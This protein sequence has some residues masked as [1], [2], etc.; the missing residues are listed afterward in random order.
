MEGGQ[1]VQDDRERLGNAVE[2]HD[3]CCV[4]CPVGAGVDP[5]V[6]IELPEEGNN[7]ERASSVP[8]A[9]RG[10]GGRRG[11]P[12]QGNG[13]GDLQI[14]RDTCIAAAVS[15]ALDITAD[16]NIAVV[17]GKIAAALPGRPQG[18]ALS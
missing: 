13:A 2:A 11:Q 7:H 15:T 10:K 3:V 16:I 8:L 12:Q 1:D 14:A 17:G 6:W 5:L 4:R 9:A 18:T